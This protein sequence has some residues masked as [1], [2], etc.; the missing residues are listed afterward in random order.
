MVIFDRF[1]SLNGNKSKYSSK[2]C[3]FN[4]T[5]SLL[6]LVK[7]KITQ[8]QPTAYAVHSVEPIVP[9]FR[10]KSFNVR[11]FPYLLENSFSSL[12]TENLLYSYWFYQNVIFKLNMGNFNM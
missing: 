5:T 6:Y 2:L 12:L 1:F 10:R 7:G 9:D 11:F 4:L 3:D 8:K